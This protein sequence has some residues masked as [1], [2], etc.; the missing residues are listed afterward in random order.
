[1]KNLFQFIIIKLQ[2]I[3][4]LK[5]V[6]ELP[7]NVYLNEDNIF[8]ADLNKSIKLNNIAYSILSLVNG[9]NS[10]DDLVSILL[11][12]YNVEKSVLERDIKTLFHGLKDKNL[13]E[14]KLKGNKLLAYF[15]NLFI[16][17][18]TYKKRYTIPNS[19]ILTFLLLI[20]VII[21][22]LFI[23]VLFTILASVF[24]STSFPIDNTII[25][26]YF[27][28]IFAVILGFVLHEW[29]HIVTSRLNKQK[30][31]GY[32]LLKKF[33]I[34]VVK[35]DSELGIMS[36]LLGPLIPSILG[37]FLLLLSLN[38]H[39]TPLFLVGLAFSTNIINLLPFTTDGKRVLQKI[40]IKKLIKWKEED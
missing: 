28:F 37:I 39:N 25:I 24:F 5:T 13:I 20:Y 31:H 2:L 17:Q 11:K 9:K 10:T 21:K 1:M 18:Y 23:L 40:L 35:D 22:K 15:F 14:C 6:Y 33:T 34:S 8:D 38:T 30:I 19:N 4:N 3:L 12:K 26:Y 16:G 36:T 32:I 29:L 7:K 27:T